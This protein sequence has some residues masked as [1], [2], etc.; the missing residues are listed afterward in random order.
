MIAA[1]PPIG[2]PLQSAIYDGWVHHR[3]RSPRRHDLRFHM[4]VMWI[5]LS[6]LPALFASRWLWSVDRPN[7]A[8]F[9]RADFLGGADG[10]PL[11]EAVR[12]AVMQA[13][14]RRPEGPIRLLAH[15]R[16]F[17]HCF[18]PVSFYYC[19]KPDGKGLDAIVA[20][21]TNTPWKQRHAYVLDARAAAARGGPMR[22][23]F[24]KAFHVSPFMPMEQ[25]YDW[26]FTEPGERL[27]VHMRNLGPEGRMFDAT[28]R[29]KRREITSAA[30]AA[31][32]ARFPAMTI[33][34]VAKIHWEAIRLWI[35]GVGVH[36]HPATA[37]A[38]GSGA[39]EADL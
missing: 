9:R 15:L 8:W 17:G 5:D 10:G 25:E 21:I 28:M 31:R 34:V 38:G 4:F 39:R 20:E 27:A 18:N 16:Y 2:R 30:L 26:T 24:G 37:V 6:E 35:K 19:Y 36:P 22:F 7:L 14:G 3:R 32:L 23:R 1:P 29:L 11:D 13:L 12:A 33:Q